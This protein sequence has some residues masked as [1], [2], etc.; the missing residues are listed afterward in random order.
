VLARAVRGRASGSTTG[1]PKTAASASRL[2]AGGC[3]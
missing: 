3:R 1:S 2:T